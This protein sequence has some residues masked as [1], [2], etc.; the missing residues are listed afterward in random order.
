MANALRKNAPAM[1]PMM[2]KA[3]SRLWRGRLPVAWRCLWAPLPR[4]GEPWARLRFAA[5]ALAQLSGAQQALGKV[6]AVLGRA[7]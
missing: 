6:K 7:P 2:S 4:L 1:L 3:R 5:A